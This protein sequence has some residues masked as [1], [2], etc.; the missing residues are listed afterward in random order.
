MKNITVV[1]DIPRFNRII[2]KMAIPYDSTANVVEI[3]DFIFTYCKTVGK[4]PERFAW[5]LNDDNVLCRDGEP[6]KRVGPKVKFYGY[7]SD[8]EYYHESRLF[9]RED[10]LMPD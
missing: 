9:A 2:R 8:A 7:T 5:T 1:Y 10:A 4:N 3:Y 6:V